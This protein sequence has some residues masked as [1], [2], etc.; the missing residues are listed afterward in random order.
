M[1]EHAKVLKI[2]QLLTE[3][4]GKPRAFRKTDAVDEVVRT[5]LSQHTNDNNSFPA[6]DELKRTFRDWEA[7]MRAPNPKIERCI[8][9]AGLSKI[10][11]VRI[12]EV[13]VEI[14]RREGRIT[15]KALGGMKIGEAL[16]YLIS[17][18]GVGPKTAAC[19]LLFSFNMPVM[20]VDTHIFRVTKRLGLI[21]RNIGI[22][23]AHTY[24]T[25]LVPKDLIYRFHLSII[26][27]GR[28]TCKA[29]NPRCGFCILCSMCPW[30]DK[31]HYIK[32]GVVNN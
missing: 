29:Q 30:K 26:K 25:G 22:D 7:A 9:R 6:F 13:L 21:P 11:A 12:K 5:I 23:D 19:V 4:Y 8:R 20:P 2:L 31:R 3:A 18:K 28:M 24:L 1:T 27:H 16:D 32:Y 17:L 10:K 14:K 15:L